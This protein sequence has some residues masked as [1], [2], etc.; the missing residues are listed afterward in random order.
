MNL[1]SFRRAVDSCPDE[2]TSRLGDLPALYA[3][4][5]L[6]V[7]SNF[8]RLDVSKELYK[9]IAGA[10]ASGHQSVW[11][12]CRNLRNEL[13]QV[14]VIDGTALDPTS[15]SSIICWKP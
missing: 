11:R 7:E 14:H 2:I 1:E 3:Y 13:I 6:P 10:F 5:G 15:R 4:V 12:H 8:A 9:K